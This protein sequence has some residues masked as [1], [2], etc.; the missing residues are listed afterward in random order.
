MTEDSEVSEEYKFS[1]INLA[2]LNYRYVIKDLLKR[3]FVIFTAAVILGLGGFVYGNEKSS[4][5]YS[6]EMTLA[7]TVR[8]SVNDAYANLKTT[9]N[10]SGVMSAVL[11]SSALKQLVCSDLKTD[12]VPG[13]ISAKEVESTNLI[14]LR[15]TSSSPEMAFRLVNSAYNNLLKV[16]DI[17]ATD[18]IIN[19]LDPAGIQTY[20][21]SLRPAVKSAATAFVIGALF[22]IVISFIM[23]ALD[24]SVKSRKQLENSVNLKLFAAIPEEKKRATV[25]QKKGDVKKASMLITDLTRSTQYV[26]AVKKMRISIE[27]EKEKNGYS[28]F[29]VTST[30]ENEGKS[31]VASNIAVTLAK[32]NHKGLLID[33]DLHKPSLNRIFEANVAPEAEIGLFL[34]D[35]E[36]RLCK[37]YKDPVTGVFLLFGTKSYRNSCEMLASERMRALI[38]SVR[39]KYE[40]IIIDTPPIGVVPDADEMLSISDASLLVVRENETSYLVINDVIRHL[41]DFEAKLLGCV[42]NREIVSPVSA[43][44]S[45]YGYND[46]GYYYHG[47]KA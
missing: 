32:K 3:W 9:L 23:S 43:Y 35:K 31:T 6:S 14:T 46:Y 40:Y 7:I 21:F 29:C 28:V 10:L 39:N 42:Y 15:A 27:R 13:T 19:V 17:I 41:N 38:K 4:E 8:G 34:S 36:K 25:G 44:G 24:T 26:E 37:L 5:S 2:E 22:G 47:S 1:E 12:T 20:S 18:A 11:E 16:S 33:A 45:H 30:F